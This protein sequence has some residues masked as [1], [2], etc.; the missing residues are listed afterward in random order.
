M[1]T[2]THAAMSKAV[3]EALGWPGDR[4]MAA[5]NAMYP[6]EVR[7]VTLE[8]YGAYVIGHNCASLCHFTIPSSDGKFMGYS[9][10]LDRSVPALDL[11]DV[12]VMPQPEAWGWPVAEHPDLVNREP[13]AKLVRELRGRMSTEAD[14]ITYTA[15]SIMAGWL[16]ECYFVLAKRLTGAIR[17]DA[18]DTVGGW[19]LHF[20][21][22]SAMPH[23][24]NGTM[25]H[26]HSGFE[27][28]VD[29]KYRQME[30]SGEIAALLKS[31][32][33]ADNAPA[34]TTLRQVVED[35]ARLSVISPCRLSAY[36]TL[37]RRGWN[38]LVKASVLRALV[39][40]VRVGKVLMGAR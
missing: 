35:T 13:F 6:D 5:R 28:D 34:G 24:A 2:S 14:E 23:H 9:W 31:L 16:S 1:N 26:G 8:K 32:V 12:E 27:G 29:E 4:N 7:A 11:S 19:A 15:G 22:D 33:A 3:L 36:H 25:L 10:L 37:Y 39:A 30:A 18:L 40:S 20:S 21:C 17:R 38:K